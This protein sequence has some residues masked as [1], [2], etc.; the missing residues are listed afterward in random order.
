[1]ANPALNTDPLRWFLCP[2]PDAAPVAHSAHKKRPRRRAGLRGSSSCTDRIPDRLHSAG[3]TRSQGKQ[4][5]KVRCGCVAL[6]ASLR[7]RYDQA[8]EPLDVKAE[9]GPGFYYFITESW[10]GFCQQQRRVASR[11]LLGTRCRM[12]PR[13]SAAGAARCGLSI[14]RLALPGHA[15]F[16]R[17]SPDA[18]GRR[19]RSRLAPRDACA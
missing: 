14:N 9:R 8:T 7:S 13:L 4:S 12:S 11:L 18:P 19:D 3:K 5:V 16:C 15:A 6:W 17:A 2:K 10:V 1:M